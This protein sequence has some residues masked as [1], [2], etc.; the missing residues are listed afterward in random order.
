MAREGEG[1]A[2]DLLNGAESGGFEAGEGEVVVRDIGGGE[3]VGGV[4][5]GE[6]EL[7]VGVERGS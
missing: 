6:R 2:D 5:G 3:V 1:L 4:I 7:W